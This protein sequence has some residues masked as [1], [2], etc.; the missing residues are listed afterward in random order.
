MRIF[1]FPTVILVLAG[2]AQAAAVEKRDLLTDLQDQTMENLK[3]AEANG[4]LERRGSCNILNAAVR[5]D[6]YNSPR[7]M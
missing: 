3:A 5:R 1:G 6:W 7:Q 4:T 2:V